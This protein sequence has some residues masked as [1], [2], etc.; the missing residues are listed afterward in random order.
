MTKLALSL[1]ATGALTL[2]MAA[3]AQ[4]ST[5]ANAQ[6]NQAQVQTQ[7]SVSVEI[8]TQI[9]KIQAAPAQERVELMNQLKER[10][11]AMSP[12]Q[13]RATMQQLRT[14]MRN[15]AEN[16]DTQDQKI[17]KKLEEMLAKMENHTT[18][19]HEEAH[20]N[21]QKHQEHAQEMQQNAHMEMER[22]EHMNQ[23]EAGE[24]FK[25]QMHG[26]VSNHVTHP[27]SEMEGP[28]GSHH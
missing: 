1:I 26:E 23:R 3:T 4:V 13:R 10:I 19:M 22:N 11:A 18:Q 24:Q 12:D 9:E 5:S 21:M 16:A 8:T 25:A 28:M 17:I 27:A 2:G 14:Q 6:N 20:S 7:A 15:K